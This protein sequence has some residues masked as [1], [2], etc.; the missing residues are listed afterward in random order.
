MFA[1]FFPFVSL[2]LK[3]KLPG[4][5]AFAVLIF[6]FQVSAWSLQD[7]QI[8]KY[9]PPRRHDSS[10]VPDYVLHIT[11]ETVSI[12]C[13]TRPS[14]LINGSLPGPELRIPPG[15]TSW[16][17]VY[18]EMTDKNAT[19]HW[20]GISQ[21]SAIFSDGT[22]SASQWPIAPLHFFDY[23]VHPEPD[24][25][26]TYFYHSHVG[27]QMSTASGP[28]IIEDVPGPPYDYDDELIVQL[29][30]Y[31]KKPDH[32]IEEGLTARPFFWSGETSAVLIN[33][34]GVA[35]GATAGN[36]S[37]KLPVIYV[38]PGK[39]YRMRFIGT[40]ALSMVQL[41]I[42]DHH[43]FKI[44]D[45][46]GHYK[47][48]YTESFMQV[49]TGQRFDVLFKTKSAEELGGKTDYLIQFETRDR[50]EVY[51]GYG[52]L[53]YSG[54]KPSI[55]TAPSKPPLSL[56]H[57]SYSWLEYALEP[58]LPNNFPTA[59][60]VTR[61]VVIYDRQ[62]LAHTYIWRSNGDQWNH[63]TIYDTPGD[64]PYLVNI[65]EKGPA[66]IPNFERALYNRGWDPVTYTFPA[67]IG[68][69]LEIIW[70]NTGSLVHDNGGVDY[71][72]FHAH[73]GHYYDIGSK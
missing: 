61:R 57:P 49:S 18:N 58:L 47:K 69:V 11:Y 70:V 31:F 63:S 23:E 36:G 6:S 10:F 37:C 64:R 20:H 54:G 65:Y 26:G 42:V 62:V 53:R 59:D 35:T 29:G 40:T 60:E 71:H 27:F 50:P 66:A 44:I 46:D 8:S 39:T 12:G 3:M 2:A 51:T 43:E 38:D 7:E 56:S 24:D 4:A 13:Q 34:V 68:E 41:G 28:L 15:K 45:A 73:G 30:D 32:A 9:G 5:A 1:H 14:A 33:G 22:P 72:P 55:S 25:A 16:I 67:K 19:M 21:R 48:P 52:V 17:R